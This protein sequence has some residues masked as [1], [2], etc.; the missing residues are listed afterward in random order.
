MQ[1]VEV[2]YICCDCAMFAAQNAF[3]SLEIKN[4]HRH[5]VETTH[6]L[7]I[8]FH[9]KDDPVTHKAAEINYKLSKHPSPSYTDVFAARQSHPEGHRS[10]VTI[11]DWHD[12]N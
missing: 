11:D 10:K 6:V 12:L 9:S 1:K 7:F 5:K 8:S 3:S 4:V 2:L